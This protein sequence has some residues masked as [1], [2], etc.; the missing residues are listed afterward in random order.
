MTAEP[1]LTPYA[2][3]ADSGDGGMGLYLHVPFCLRKCPYCSFFSVAGG[4]GRRWDY[5]RAVEGQVRRIIESGWTEGRQAATIF[6]GG[7]TPSLLEPEQLAALLA[8]FRRH[9]PMA[10][11]EVET[12]VEV[13]PA[14]VGG[15]ELARLC[16]AGYNRISIG[17]QSL[18]DRELREIGRPHTAAE[19]IRT[20]HEAR[21][22]GFANLNM[23]LMYGLPAQTVASWEQ[24]LVAAMEL[25][26]DHLAVYELTIE[27]GTPFA[28]RRQQGSLCLPGEDEVMEMMAVTAAR[29]A[30]AEFSRY[31]ISN[32]ARPGKQ[33][34]HNINY[35]RNGWYAGLGPGAVSCLAG[36]RCRAIEDIDE[37]CRRIGSGKEWWS[38]IEELDAEAR[39]RETV[40]MGLR[41]TDGIS[42]TEIARRFNVDIL[43]YYGDILLRL[44]EQGL[45]EQSNDRLRL[46]PA[47][48]VFANQVMARLV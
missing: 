6:V 5:I 15:A 25:E 32:Y 29:T 30:Q 35:W 43:A 24:T 39:L 45:V 48:M 21:G 37:F 8:Y 34:R 46:S 10:A 42:M 3:V 36:R 13:N 27:E 4:N 47:G 22:A 17:V 33:C 26:P 9:F 23:D 31:E 7:G 11:E 44:E 12:S 14:T 19:A 1:L 16:R 20:V 18:V 28:R 41:M 2:D 40:I 38:D